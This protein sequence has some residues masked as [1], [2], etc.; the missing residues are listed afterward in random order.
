MSAFASVRRD[1]LFL[2]DVSEAVV[3]TCGDS[4][5]TVRVRA[6]WALGAS[7]VRACAAL[8]VVGCVCGKTAGGQRLTVGPAPCFKGNLCDALVAHRIA[9]GSDDADSKDAVPIP[10]A[11]LQRVAQAALS[12]AKDR[13]KVR[14]GRGGLVEVC[15]LH[16][17]EACLTPVPSAFL[18]LR[19]VALTCVRST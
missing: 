11:L 4:N 13:D 1:A 8:V 10:L 3:H 18:A 12:S 17:R 16:R 9:H 2:A 19:F 15:G 6:S 14:R 5:L 7:R